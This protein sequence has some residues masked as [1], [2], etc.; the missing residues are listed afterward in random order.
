[1]VDDQPVCSCL[2]PANQL[3]GKTI[4]TVEAHGRDNL[5]PVQ[6]AL[7]VH[8][9]LQCG[10]H[11]GYHLNG[12]IFDNGGCANPHPSTLGMA[13]MA[14]DAEVEINGSETR[15]I[16]AIY[17][18]G[19]DHNRDHLLTDSEIITK[20]IMPAPVAEKAAYFWAS[21]RARAEWATV[22]CV[23]RLVMDED[24]ISLYCSWR[25]GASAYA[26]GECGSNIGGQ[27]CQGGDL[28]R[29]CCAGW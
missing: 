29:S 1:M 25:S 26:F 2:L 24:T 20:V 13:L 22:E 3:E 10:G 5:H 9:G 17:G 19:S 12:V 21:Q 16:A 18:D 8:D 14:Y 28:C 27:A 23:A 15:S 4:Q 7:M 11:E 6:K